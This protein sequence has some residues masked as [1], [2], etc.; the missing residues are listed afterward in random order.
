MTP[1]EAEAWFAGADKPAAKA[2][3]TTALQAIAPVG[4]SDQ[5][6]SSKPRG[7]LKPKKPAAPSEASRKPKESSLIDKA[8]GVATGVLRAPAQALGGLL[9][10]SEDLA[11]FATAPFT[12]A[13]KRNLNSRQISL[14]KKAQAKVDAGMDKEQAIVSSLSAPEQALYSLSNAAPVR[15]MAKW[16]DPRGTG[17]THWAD[18]LSGKEG[19]VGKYGDD[20]W[21]QGS[22]EVL[23]LV[24]GAVTGGAA[25][26]AAGVTTKVG[27]VTS[28]ISNPV[29]RTGANIAA[30]SVGG[31]AAEAV[32]VDPEQE[33]LSNVLQGMGVKN[34]FTDWL[35]YEGDDSA[36]E[37]RFKNAIEGGVT[38][39]ALDSLFL[40]AKY[41]VK[42]A[43]AAKGVPGAAEE[44]QAIQTTLQGE[45]DKVA[46]TLDPRVRATL[47]ENNASVATPM[48]AAAQ[49]L[50]DA[51]ASIREKA[52]RTKMLRQAL[53]EADDQVQ[54]ELPAGFGVKPTA[55]RGA[56]L[57]GDVTG[58]L[59]KAADTPSPV[60]DELLQEENLRA[61]QTSP[62][63]ADDAV[64][65]AAAKPTLV[66]KAVKV[67]TGKD[68]KASLPPI[69]EEDLFR[70]GREFPEALWDDAKGRSIQK[71]LVAN[72][73]RANELGRSSDEWDAL[74]DKD[75]DFTEALRKRQQEVIAEG[76]GKSAEKL[77]R[78]TD[79]LLKA[80][81]AD[82]E[83]S[84]QDIRVTK[85][86]KIVVPPAAKKVL[87]DEGVGRGFAEDIGLTDDVLYQGVREDGPADEV[88]LKVKGPTSAF[89]RI[90]GE[91][92]REDLAKMGKELT[93][94][95]QRVAKYGGRYAD[96]TRANNPV[97]AARIGEMRIGNIGDPDNLAGILRASLA[98]IPDRAPR[99]DAD[100]FAT[101]KTL[102]EDTGEDGGAILAMARQIAGQT[103][104]VDDM[105]GLIR[106]F[107][108]T[109]AQRIDDL[110]LPNV[111]WTKAP[112]EQVTAA[113]RAIH[114]MTTMSSYVQSTKA[115]LGRGLR[116]NQLPNAD[117]Y[118]SQF[119][120][121][122]DKPKPVIEGGPL[123]R[124]RKEVADWLELWR[125]TKGDPKLR[126]NMLQ[127]KISVPSAGLYVRTA[128]ANYFT[129]SILSAPRTIALNIAGPTLIST[130]RTI[131]RTSGAATI[132]LNPLA[133]KAT[134][135]A[136]A[137]VARESARVQMQFLE[138]IQTAFHYAVQSGRAN[139]PVLG[140][141]GAAIDTL[142]SFGPL[143]QNLVESS[144]KSWTGAAAVGYQFGNLIN[145]FPRAFARVNNGLDD[146]AKRIA[147]YGEVR[148][149]ATVEA[150]E[151]GM[152][153]DARDAFIR[154]RLEDAT[155]DMGEATDQAM[156]QRAELSTLTKT[157][158]EDGSFVRK[159]S[160]GLAQ[161]RRDVPELRYIIPIYNVAAN[162]LGETLRR[163]PI[164]QLPF[165]KGA[166]AESVAELAGERGAVLQAEAHGRMIMGAAFL[167]AGFQL[168]QMG[169]MTGSGPKDPQ[170]RKV[171]LL[172]H[173]PYSIRVG[174]DWVSYAKLD[175]IGG[176]MSI[177]ATI[178][179]E[180][181][182]RAADE[183][184][185]DVIMSGVAAAAIWFKDKS[186][187]RT[188][189]EVLSM[190]SNPLAEPDKV[191]GRI[192]GSIV[193]SVVP[194]ALRTTVT[195]PLDPTLRLK[196][197]FEDYLKSA[198]PG[199]SETLEPVR[200]VLGE[201][202]Q[203]PADTFAEALVPVVLAPQV[204]WK[205]DP[206][207]TELSDLYAATG[208]GA[209]AEPESMSYGHFEENRVKMEN[210][211][212]IGDRSR[213]LRQTVT[214]NGKT[215]R[216]E[217][218]DL[219]ASEDYISAY[220]IG[221][222]RN[223][224]A[225]GE[226]SRGQMVAKVFEKY[227]ESIRTQIARESDVGRA[228]L[229]A[230]RVK[231]RDGF[232]TR[233][234]T[235]EELVTDPSLYEA[236]GV[237]ASEFERQLVQGDDGKPKKN[238]DEIDTTEDSATDELVQALEER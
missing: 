75:A 27:A 173:Q 87:D 148:L 47:F 207:V 96:I 32:F 34:E 199:L 147:Y 68:P 81:G 19:P 228:Y 171:W 59:A 5:G 94:F 52:A 153:G 95:Q 211:Q 29:L 220:D 182:Y 201:A 51:F 7:P 43:R 41:W 105:M 99:S 191:L 26:K 42:S 188:V 146:F 170:D 238:P 110:D 192:G 91:T 157:P 215:L 142:G 100:L 177:P 118:V 128:F 62:S 114:D 58:D 127:G 24:Y 60:L 135:D 111:D 56:D 137:S 14:Q 224:T 223:E 23:G 120:K 167:T 160:T 180:S 82:V 194:A 63:R 90:V 53:L 67:V 222:G 123:P 232:R 236:S 174:D 143:T 36:M 196:T 117:E 13:Y 83:I 226:A 149:N 48:E 78:D 2:Q 181:I 161:A 49:S 164:A 55:P 205:D 69:E 102:A 178:R 74:M 144:G 97:E 28:T 92:T 227:N 64:Q 176:L 35:A 155:G 214:V 139:K 80:L 86:G 185:G 116:V 65:E 11:Q 46:E 166:F 168:N 38:G 197:T 104:N 45:V 212:S 9:D 76:S 151:K 39:A 121:T 15:A 79:A 44:A 209:G 189:S 129:A 208:Y 187:L 210:G 113:I 158:G 71:K 141:G 156:L 235:V 225:S 237:D 140:G 124:T 101:V 115:A 138:H 234:L 231:E 98:Q 33:R 50:D 183:R 154:Q 233:A 203:R 145:V 190:G 20:G 57:T 221:P 213:Q 136:A 84:P 175:I 130:L 217:L 3:T 229:V 109:F 133:S 1:E 17:K 179:D 22:T 134:R 165:T 89:D 61:Y 108:G 93:L 85:S 159:F 77:A 119:R 112:E 21:N 219:F 172:N 198:I 73:D 107:W 184:M 218:G 18:A 37:G 195:E 204:S 152:T 16:L 126:A 12:D 162:S 200:N 122:Q 31:G 40:V 25:L 193:Q 4:G 132:M 169:L 206:I 125:A 8:T 216:E 6:F 163:L 66:D 103:Q 202:I 131:E 30:V 72:L 150:A 230:A 186:A 106:T 10:T 88:I 54:Q 70:P